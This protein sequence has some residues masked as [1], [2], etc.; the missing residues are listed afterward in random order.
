MKRAALLIAMMAMVAAEAP[1]MDV[2]RNGKAAAVVVAEPLAPPQRRWASLLGIT[3]G[4]LVLGGMSAAFPLFPIN[5][6]AIGSWGYFGVIGVV[7]A[8]T[9]SVALPIPYLLIVARAGSYLDP[10]MVAL[11]AGPLVRAGTR[12]DLRLRVLVHRRLRRRTE[13]V[14]RRDRRRRRH[15]P[16][17][18]VE[19][20]PR[21]LSG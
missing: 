17:L 5:W 6:E 9:A 10:F 18:L 20:Y 4:V 1:A 21:L 15:A 12:V 11:V 13:S 2:V 7:L 19:V 8:A 16:L 14:L 3:V